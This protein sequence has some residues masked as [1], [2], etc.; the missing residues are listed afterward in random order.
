ME[1]KKIMDGKFY[2]V[3]AEAKME[4]FTAGLYSDKDLALKNAGQRAGEDRARKFVLEAIA[5]VEPNYDVTV[6]EIK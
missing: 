1:N 5:S 4:H 3:M 2:V 6:K